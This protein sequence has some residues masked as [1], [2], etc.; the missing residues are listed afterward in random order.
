M[1]SSAKLTDKLVMFLQQELSLAG[2]PV[3]QIKFMYAA[4]IQVPA[5]TGQ[6]GM[7][8]VDFS[9]PGTPSKGIGIFCSLPPDSAQLFKLALLIGTAPNAIA[10]QTLP[11]VAAVYNSYKIAPGWEQK[12]L[13][14]Y[15]P[16][17][18][19]SAGP[20]GQGPG[21]AAETQMYLRAMQNQQRVIDHGFTCADAGILG[22]G[23][24]WET[25][26]E[27]G[28]WAPNF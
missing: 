9:A 20:G 10:A 18:S 27:C 3:A 4:P 1:P 13:S 25:P 7:F 2:K 24:N 26:R 17:A 28:G 5:G 6:C 16:S 11:T 21:S 23:S 22:D 14:P 8:A 19:A 15:T 12:M